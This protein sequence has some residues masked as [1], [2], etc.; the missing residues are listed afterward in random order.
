[1]P[2]NLKTLPPV[3]LCVL[4]RSF[5][6]TSPGYCLILLPSATLTVSNLLTSGSNGKKKTLQSTSLVKVWDPLR[7]L[8]LLEW[9]KEGWE[10]QGEGTQVIVEKTSRKGRVKFPVMQ[11]PLRYGDVHSI[12]NFVLT[13]PYMEQISYIILHMLI[14]NKYII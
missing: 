12:P 10:G 2:S 11:I 5:P 9:A 8:Q 14:H 13:L 6:G 1:M 3:P 4:H 7:Y